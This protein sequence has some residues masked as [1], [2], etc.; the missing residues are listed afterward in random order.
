MA[1]HSSGALQLLGTGFVLLRA[2][3]LATG[4]GPAAQRKLAGRKRSK[5]LIYPGLVKSHF[6]DPDCGE[7]D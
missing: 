6:E 7:K 2:T 4:P 3:P 1:Q 5:R